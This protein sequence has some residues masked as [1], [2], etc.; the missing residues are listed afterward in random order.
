MLYSFVLL[1]TVLCV[2]RPNGLRPGGLRGKKKLNHKPA[3]R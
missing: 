1:C 3:C 2:P